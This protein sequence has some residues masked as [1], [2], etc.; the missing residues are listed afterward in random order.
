MAT[1]NEFLE[2]RIAKANFTVS[3]SAAAQ[4]LTSGVFLPAGAL[5]TG[6]TFI[7]TGAPTV[8][9]ASNHIGIMAYNTALSSSVQVIST[10]LIKNVASAQTVP[11]I[12]TLVSTA[13]MYIP[14]AGE[15]GLSVS[16]SSGTNA[17]TWN[18]T[19]YIGYVV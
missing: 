8:A 11:T 13:G 14:V 17:I 15:V 9:N 12:M 2:G 7:A 18:P 3:E 5:V 16:A 6:V 19:V 4:A 1:I 10:A